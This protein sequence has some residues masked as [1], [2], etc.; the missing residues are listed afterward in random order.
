[1][2]LSIYVFATNNTQ[3]TSPPEIWKIKL[4]SFS[5]S[6]LESQELARHCH[7]QKWTIPEEHKRGWSRQELRNFP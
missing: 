5:K 1:M 4:F 3:A 2:L 7:Q 6:E